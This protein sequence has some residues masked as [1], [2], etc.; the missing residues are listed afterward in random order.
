[1]VHLEKVPSAGRHCAKGRHAEAAAADLFW[2]PLELQQCCRCCGEDRDRCCRAA[3]EAVAALA[4][5][6]RRGVLGVAGGVHR[7]I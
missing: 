7:L 4:D 6:A 5:R 2:R 1:M 3:T